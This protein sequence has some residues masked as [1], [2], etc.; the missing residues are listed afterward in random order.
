[1]FLGYERIYERKYLR[2]FFLTLEIGMVSPESLKNVYACKNGICE[3]KWEIPDYA[4]VCFKK[5]AKTYRNADYEV[6]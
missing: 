2:N 5:R 1:M 6:E 4:R 3:A